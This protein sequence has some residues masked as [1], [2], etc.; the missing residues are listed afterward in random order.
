M[1]R[2]KHLPITEPHLTDKQLNH[3]VSRLRYKNE[4]I[5]QQLSGFETFGWKEGETL[6]K[7][8]KEIQHLLLKLGR[9]S[10]LEKDELE[11]LNR[12]LNQ[13]PR[14]NLKIPNKS[15]LKVFK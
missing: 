5:N 15:I 10:I 12:H 2:K 7:S 9:H 11:M 6:I 1:F 3:A 13:K 14:I 8:K 4:I